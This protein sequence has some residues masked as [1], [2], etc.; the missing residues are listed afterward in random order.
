MSPITSRATRP[1]DQ[2]DA[3]IT[4]PSIRRRR[5]ILGTV[6]VMLAVA[7]VAVVQLFIAWRSLSAASSHLSA[8]L[9]LSRDGQ[10][11][12]RTDTRQTVARDVASGRDG[13]DTAKLNLWLWNPIL[14]RLG[15]V[16]GVGGELA[17]AYILADT[18]SESATG[19]VDLLAGL[20]PVW[21]G[22]GRHRGP[23]GLMARL[24]PGLARGATH[25]GEAARHFDRAMAHL[26]GVPPAVGSAS[27]N[28]KINRLRRAL[29]VLKGASL[30]L[31][32]AP[33]ILGDGS[34][35]RI[36]LVWEN[37]A[38]I[39]P[40]GGFI[41]AADYISIVRGRITTRTFGSYFA[42]QPYVP[43]PAPL[44]IYTG[45]GSFLFEDSNWSPDFPLSARYERWMFGLSTGK[46]APMIVNV[47][48][49]AS[50]LAATGP[51]YVPRYHRW[52][53]SRDVGYWIE[54]YHLRYV[55]HL[56]PNAS[57]TK[58]QRFLADLFR[59]ILDHLSGLSAP[60]LV[61]LANG[62]HQAIAAQ[63]ILMYDRD[64][65]V[66][67]AIQAVGAAGGIGPSRHDSLL[68]VD[69]NLSY[70]K[71]NPYISETATYD[72]TIRPDLSASAILR[73]RYHNRR[74]PANLYG[75]GPFFT[76]KVVHS[77]Q[78]W[79][80]VYIPPG[81]RVTS[82]SGLSGCSTSGAQGCF[83]SPRPAYG[84]TEL[85]QDLL[86]P[87]YATRVATFRYRLP[88]AIFQA[89]GAGRYILT[90]RRQP[91]SNLRSILLRVHV[92]SGMSVSRAGRRTWALRI[93]LRERG[94]TVAVPISG[95]S[96]SPPALGATHGPWTDPWLPRD[97][98]VSSRQSF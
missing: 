37:P 2:S 61:R 39:R 38:Q 13:F 97:I 40:T 73:L 68:V 42:N 88:P 92:A 4:V 25:F 36:L 26:R 55:R 3:T 62:F 6:M 44:S 80:R 81:A 30:W 60:G 53:N 89:R 64:P 74:S 83:W 87:E 19:A 28:A 49:A 94:A 52:V 48:G 1:V 96:G 17:S 54:Y 18:G 82:E 5:L 20:E 58:S 69:D 21:S 84:M 32:V 98:F 71:I 29:P 65:A 57:D 22:F 63:N 14:N 23:S 66:E 86:L 77:Y 45:E 91:S 56:Q 50:I 47:S 33:T 46:L 11:L 72:V 31:S 90:V 8:A 10:L 59:A 16:P 34:P 79:I 75:A 24:A 7:L 85:G 41:P 15:W 95:A 9:A 12:T 27:L 35:S 67:Q 93:Q 78:D 43:L 51:I 76:R 70:N